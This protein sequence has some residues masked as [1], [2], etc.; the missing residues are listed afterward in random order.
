ML[1]SHFI[2]YFA[3]RDLKYHIW[4]AQLLAVKLYV[5]Y[6]VILEIVL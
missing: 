4:I 3:I 5:K 2:N 1:S 6:H